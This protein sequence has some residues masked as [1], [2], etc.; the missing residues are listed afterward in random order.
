ILI[1]GPT[2]AGKS[3]FIEAL[4][5]E[6]QSLAI[7]KD[8]L[9]GFTQEVTVYKLQNTAMTYNINGGSFPIYLIDTPGF[10]DGKISEMEVVSKVR[11]W[12]KAGGHYQINRVLYLC[13]ITD[14]RASGSKRRTIKMFQSL[15][16]GHTKDKVTIVTTMWD[17]VHHPQ[18][19]ERAEANFAQLQNDIWKAKCLTLVFI[20]AKL[21]LISRK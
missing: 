6:G 4:A 14:T 5:G 20:S 8:Q 16:D 12:M 9:S 10:S 17:R 21:T 15:I 1:I 7:S 19:K 2:G 11:S 3:S 13:P 18:V